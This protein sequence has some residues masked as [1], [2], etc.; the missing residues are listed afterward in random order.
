M[1]K[2]LSFD[3]S[4]LLESTTGTRDNYTFEGPIVFENMKLKAPL[5]GEVEVMRIEEGFNVRATNVETK[6]ESLCDRCLKPY[7]QEIIIKSTER[8]FYM[9]PPQECEDK[10]DLFMVDK[11]RLVVDVTEMLRQEIILHFPPNLVCS[12]GCKGLCAVCGKDK[13]KSLCKCKE[14]STEYKPLSKLKELLK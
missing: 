8:I 10:A 14:V 2:I 4:K 3:I 13:N 9:N 5:K 12:R 1:G 11:K 7:G 6:V